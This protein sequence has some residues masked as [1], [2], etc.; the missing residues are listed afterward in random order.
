MVS[1]VTSCTLNDGTTLTVQNYGNSYS[2]EAFTS[3]DFYPAIIINTPNTSTDYHTLK[4]DKV[5]GN[6]TIDIYAQSSQSADKLLNQ[7]QDTIETY[8]S[9]LAT[10]GIRRV[11]VEDTNNDFSERNGIKV[12]MRNIRF[13]FVFY[14]PK[15]S[16]Y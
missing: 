13:S 4:Q 10:N 8:K 11:K 5:N 9:T 14:Y 15:T 12:H 1:N 16:S 7:V 3:K 6:I 2:D